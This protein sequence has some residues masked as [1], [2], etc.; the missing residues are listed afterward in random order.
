MKITS[1]TWPLLLDV[2]SLTYIGCHFKI[3]R[4]ETEGKFIKI[5][6]SKIFPWPNDRRL[7]LPVGYCSCERK[8]CKNLSH[9]TELSLETPSNRNESNPEWAKLHYWSYSMSNFIKTIMFTANLSCEFF[10][11]KKWQIN[12][13]R[14]F[15]AIVSAIALIHWYQKHNSISQ[16]HD[17]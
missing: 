5:D 9:W 11:L 1:K 3:A 14:R 10:F 13:E 8:Y 6:N 12:C 17:T 16:Q 4:I 7:P 15:L 2:I